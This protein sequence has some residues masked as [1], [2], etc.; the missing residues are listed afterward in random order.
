MANKL[1][2]SS[3]AAAETAGHTKVLQESVL[4]GQT[5]LLSMG[6]AALL[7]EQRLRGELELASHKLSEYEEQIKALLGS[8]QQ[9]VQEDYQHISS[10]LKT[11]QAYTDGILQLATDA[12]GES[13][14][15]KSLVWYTA[16]LTATF[17]VTATKRTQP[18]RLWGFAGESPSGCISIQPFV[19]FCT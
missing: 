16:V 1:L 11:I 7:N 4:E 6:R 9:G 5:A 18:A 14:F 10:S 12:A 8:I 17:L 13:F 3:A 19:S 2:D 15:V